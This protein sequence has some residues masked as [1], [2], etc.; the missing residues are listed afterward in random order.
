VLRREPGGDCTFLGAAGCTLPLEVRP[1]VCRMYP[2]DYT[3]HG[4]R[5][6]LSEGCPT[7]L[8]RPGE[9]LLRALD[10]RRDDAE[11]WRAQLYAELALEARDA[12]RPDLRPEE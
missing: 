8:L 10:M 11:R 4:I 6:S 2:Y 9:T 1:L 3:E 7:Q 5:A 12:D